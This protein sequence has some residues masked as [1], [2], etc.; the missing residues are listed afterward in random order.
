MSNSSQILGTG[1]YEQN[2]Y[3]VL[4]ACLSVDESVTLHSQFDFYAPNGINLLNWPP[5]TAVEVKYRLIY[6]TLLKGELYRS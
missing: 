5:K 4:K 3:I 1:T 2:V 6:D